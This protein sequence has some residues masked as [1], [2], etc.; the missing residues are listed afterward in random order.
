MRIKNNWK[1]SKKKKHRKL[2]LKQLIKSFEDHVFF[3]L[4]AG[5]LLNATDIAALKKL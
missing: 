3:L 5:I 1:R 2:Q 4:L